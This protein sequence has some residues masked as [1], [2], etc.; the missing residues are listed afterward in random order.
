MALSLYLHV[1]VGVG[2]G[3]G[4]GGQRAAGTRGSCPAECAME[5]PADGQRPRQARQTTVSAAR[6]H[7]LRTASTS[8]CPF[9]TLSSSGLPGRGQGANIIAPSRNSGG[10]GGGG[11]VVGG[12]RSHAHAPFNEHVHRLLVLGAER[13]AIMPRTPVLDSTLAADHHLAAR[14][15]LHALLRVAARPDDGAEE[16]VARV[17]F[18][19]H[20]ELAPTPLRHLVA[21]WGGGGGVERPQAPCTRAW[22][23]GA[24]RSATLGLSDST[25]AARS[26]SSFCRLSTTR[27]FTRW[28]FLSK[29]GSGDGERCSTGTSPMP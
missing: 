21:G 6:A 12:G 18:D 20:D 2:W 9:S 28:P 14:L 1:R 10:G 13:L 19:G 16:V 15:A 22:V 17:L 24:E 26:R 29:M 7:G 8:A 27:L 11:G 5:Q 3:G 25:S 4:G 23:E